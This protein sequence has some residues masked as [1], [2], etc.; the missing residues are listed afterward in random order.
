MARKPRIHFPG[1]IYHVTLR[2]NAKQEIFFSDEDRCR[3]L[4]LLQEGVERFG[5][6]VLAFCL[7]SNHVHLVIQVG[8]VAL[9]RIMQ[10]LSFRY[11]LWINHRHNRVGHL[12]QGRFKAF[13]V[14]ADSYLLELTAYLHLNPIRAGLGGRPETYPWSS[15]RAYLG[16]ET[17]PW[18][19]TEGVLGQFSRQLGQARRRFGD[20]VDDRVGEGH[21]DLFYGKDSRDGRIIGEDHFVTETLEQAA[22]LPERKPTLGEVLAAVLDRYR[23]AE[24][25]L[26]AAGQD[27]RCSEARALAAWAV[28]ELSDATLNELAA[29]VN[30]DASSLSAAISRLRAKALADPEIARQMQDLRRALEVTIFQA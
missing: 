25:G 23:L 7:M 5:H 10:N 13:L 19:A 6:R 9:S 15:H 17:I 8:E 2:G 21:R 26:G 1:A 3:F 18:L 28:Q 4:L 14:S 29:R 22:C 27:R 16:L 30:R 20:F 12:F 11:T 24:E